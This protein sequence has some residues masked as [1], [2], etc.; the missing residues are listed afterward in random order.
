MP[1]E[2]LAVPTPVPVAFLVCDQILVDES[3]KKTT[4]V[5]IFDRVWAAQFPTAISPHLF[6]RVIDCEGDYPVKLEYVQVSNQT[7]LGEG[8]GRI[9][10]TDRQRYTDLVLHWPVMP[11]PEPGEYEIRAWINKRFISSVR[12]TAQPRSEGAQV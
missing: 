9:V 7:I 3:T 1:D 2:N 12:I 11:F 5:G 8:E 6:L 10:S 4:I